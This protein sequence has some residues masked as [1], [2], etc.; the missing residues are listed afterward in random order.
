MDRA[1]F[2][3]G[4]DG[5]DVRGRGS[6]TAISAVT[7]VVL[8]ESWWSVTRF[9]LIQLLFPPALGMVIAKFARIAC[10]EHYFER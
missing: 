5:E 3:I 2:T 7:I 6:G 10:T 8:L 1:G 9:G 4:K